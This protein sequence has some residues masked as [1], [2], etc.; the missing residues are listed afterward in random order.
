MHIECVW[1]RSALVHQWGFNHRAPLAV[2][3]LAHK[4]PGEASCFCCCG[5]GSGH[6]REQLTSSWFVLNDEFVIDGLAFIE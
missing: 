4:A 3:A 5:K 2:K 1:P 6:S